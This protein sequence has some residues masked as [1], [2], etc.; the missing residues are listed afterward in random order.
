[1][2]LL[3]INDI[4]VDIDEATAI[5]VNYQSYDVKQVGKRFVNITNTFNIPATNHN[6]AIFGNA[7][8]VQSLSTDIYSASICNYWVSNEQLIKNSKCRVESISDRINLFLYEK[9]DIWDILKT[10]LFP[11]FLA[12]YIAWLQTS[13]L[14]SLASPYTGT[15]S[16]FIT[17]YAN[18][19]E[20]IILPFYLGN[21]ANYT[22]AGGTIEDETKIHLQYIIPVINRISDGGH[23]CTYVKSIFEYIEETYDV[24]FLTS[25]G[26]LPGNIWDDPVASTMYIPLRELNIKFSG[27][28]SAAS[29]YF[30]VLTNP[31]FRPLK[32]QRD[33]ADKT[34]YDFVNS[35]MQIF[36]I[37]KDEIEVAGE[38]VI[39]MARFDDLEWIA[40][41]KDWSGKLSGIQTFKPKIEGYAQ[42]NRIK[43]KSV[44]PEGSSLV[45]SKTLTSLNENLDKETDLFEID[46]Y[47]PS[48]D[49][50][51]GGVVPY[52][53]DTESF[54]TFTFFVSDGYT[55][56]NIDVKIL[57]SGV[58]PDTLASI[59]LQKA[60]VYLLD[61]EY[62]FLD[63]IITY[64]KWYE[65]NKWLTQSDLKDFQFFRQY[66][67]Q[68][69]NGSFFV[70]KI[71]G[72]NPDK[73][74]EP[75]K[76]ELIRLG[77]RTPVT[78][79]D[80]D[81]WTDGVGD[82]FVDSE[83]DYWI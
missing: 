35:F 53:G 29:I 6:L 83:G 25:G 74:N 39:R 20:N 3:K 70:N 78:P 77:N 36:N 33:K 9:A 56:D 19:T 46:A 31:I 15:S 67:I 16:A 81:Y 57:Q 42:T 68:E 41:V 22:P 48:F 49:P 54:K 79:P 62:N 50:I 10:V 1:M 73:S 51:V 52:M 17:T 66:W 75:T 63:N 69:L 2:R 26:V 55:T 27:T 11:D 30:E 4:I 21:L 37:L 47:I 82:A 28:T 61:S 8:N 43:Y 38:S 44:Y 72:F 65:V 80:L 7:Q 14:P 64:P 5:G 76:L 18:S 32:D 24:N 23:F 13:G 60:A 40:D 12:D 45:N 34:L 71:S 58:T 59:K